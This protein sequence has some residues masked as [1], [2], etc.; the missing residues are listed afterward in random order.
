MAEK[1]LKIAENA[2]KNDRRRESLTRSER[3]RFGN[4]VAPT[5][6]KSGK[7]SIMCGRRLWPFP[8]QVPDD[9]LWRWHPAPAIERGSGE[10][11]GKVMG[12]RSPGRRDRRAV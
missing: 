1:R 8:G 10:N 11:Y 6:E 4:V 2:I 5:P 3:S 7:L 9:K 12:G